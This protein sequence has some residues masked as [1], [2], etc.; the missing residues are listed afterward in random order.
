MTW[1]DLLFAHWPV[2]IS[3]LT[4]M[5]PAGLKLDTFQGEAWIGVV[6][7]GMSGVRH[8]LLWELPGTSRFPELNVRTY[9]TCGGKP[10]VW[11]FSLDAAN[12]L[13][14]F[15]ARRWFYLPYLHA[16]MSLRGDDDGRVHLSSRR[17]DR[18]APAARFRASYQPVGPVCPTREG[19][20]EHWLTARYCLYACDRRGRLW[21]GEIDHAPWP[22]QPATAQFD[23][24]T[25]LVPLSLSRADCSPLLHFARRIDVVAW[26]LEPV[27]V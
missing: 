15:T 17:S 16:R 6:P 2:P 5:L 25:M 12:R 26:T 14:V 23:E 21:R 24:D 7:F 22:L 18:S 8:R 19:Q 1:H 3:Q 4:P 20:L 10:G 11:F 27:E 9:V 13:A